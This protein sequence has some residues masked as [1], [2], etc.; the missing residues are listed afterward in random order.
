MGGILLIEG[1]CWMG[2]VLFGWWVLVFL[3]SGVY[4][5]GAVSEHGQ[6]CFARR[7][8]LSEACVSRGQP[9]DETGLAR[10]AAVVTPAGF[11]RHHR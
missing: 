7:A 9:A 1:W 6:H 5:F 8:I 11:V 2:L 3:V 4:G 10:R